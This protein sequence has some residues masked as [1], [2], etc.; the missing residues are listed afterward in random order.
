MV[1]IVAA[2]GQTLIV[3]LLL[4]TLCRCRDPDLLIQHLH[5]LRIGFAR[6]VSPTTATTQVVVL[7]VE[8]NL[9]MLLPVLIVVSR[10][11]IHLVDV[12]SFAAVVFAVVVRL[13]VGGDVLIIN[14]TIAV[15]ILCAHIAIDYF[16]HF[17]RS[18]NT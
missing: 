5:A 12:L 3:H 10:A 4:A 15:W 1:T 11:A 13:S 7:T 6:S 2:R 18:E 16:D 8:R 9:H 14:I 17:V